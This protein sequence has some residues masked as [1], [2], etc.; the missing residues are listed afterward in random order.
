MNNYPVILGDASSLMKHAP[1]NIKS[2][3]EISQKEADILGHF[4][5]V[6]S[7]LQ[8]S[9]WFNSK[10]SYSY[11]GGLTNASLPDHESMAVAL[12][13]VRQLVLKVSMMWFLRDWL[14]LFRSS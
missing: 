14:N 4:V 10:S 3:S 8:D 1:F 2:N 13:Y 9:N 7:L 12:L 6:V 5:H 11:Q